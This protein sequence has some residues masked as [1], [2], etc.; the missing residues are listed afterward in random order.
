M[1]RPFGEQNAFVKIGSIRYLNKRASTLNTTTRHNIIFIHVEFTEH[2][3]K[4]EQLID[5]FLDK[6]R[7]RIGTRKEFFKVDEKI[8]FDIIKT[9]VRIVEPSNT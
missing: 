2:Y 8:A 1:F 4:A 7:C 6:Y 3:K 5:K 9:C